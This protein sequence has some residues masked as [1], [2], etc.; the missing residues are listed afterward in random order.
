MDR[1]CKQKKPSCFLGS[2]QKNRL[3]VHHQHFCYK[4]T[5]KAHVKAPSSC[6]SRHFGFHYGN[7]LSSPLVLIFLLGYLKNEVSHD[8]IAFKIL[9]LQPI[10]LFEGERRNP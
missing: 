2:A 9:D 5:F 7:I 10:T 6:L 3:S 4:P 8:K 1:F